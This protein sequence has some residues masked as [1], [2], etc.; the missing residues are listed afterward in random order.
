[1]I[2]RLTLFTFL[3]IHSHIKKNIYNDSPVHVH[4]NLHMHS[5]TSTNIRVNG[6]QIKVQKHSL[7]KSTILI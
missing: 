5:F 3:N 7:K 4:L 2:W 1:M 6:N